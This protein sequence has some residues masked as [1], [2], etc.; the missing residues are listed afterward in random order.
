MG[1]RIGLVGLNGCG[2]STVIKL[3]TDAMKPVRGTVT[4]HS[5]LRLGYYSQHE[6]ESLQERGMADPSLTALPL[7]SQDVAGELTE[8]DLRGLLGSLGLPGRTASDVPLAKLSGGQLV[9]VAL[10]MILWRAPQLLVLDEITTHLDYHT[11][12]ALSTAL[13]EWNGAVVV[14]SHDRFLIRRV[15]EGEVPPEWERDD[16]DGDEGND[17]EKELKRRRAVYLL[18]GGKMT[19]LED[20]VRGFERSLEKRIAKLEGT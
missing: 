17:E 6:V 2:K 18:K 16:E 8:A 15:V 12:T 4:H 20:G 19:L 14:V 9:R 1:D 11:V 13:T 10:A 5:R 7:L 3:I